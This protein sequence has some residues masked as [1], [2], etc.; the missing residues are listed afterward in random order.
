MIIYYKNIN[1]QT[2]EKAEK[3]LSD[4]DGFVTGGPGRSMPRLDAE[5]AIIWNGGNRLPWEWSEKTQQEIS[6]QEKIEEQEKTQVDAYKADIE[7][8]KNERIRPWRD[9]A[10]IEWFDSLRSKPELWNEQ[11]QEIKD[12]ALTLRRDLLDY[13]DKFSNYVTDKTVENR[14]PAK[15]SYITQ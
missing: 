15:P 10:L 7:L 2:K 3:L 9:R 6:L 12:E 1:V 13:P 5:L 4:M 11:T 14:R 8:W